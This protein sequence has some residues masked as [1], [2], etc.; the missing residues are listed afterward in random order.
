MAFEIFTSTSGIRVSSGIASLNA[1]GQLVFTTADLRAVSIRDRYVLLTDSASKRIAIR[2]PREGDLD[3]E[4]RNMKW[5]KTRTSGKV[6][7]RGAL[8]QLNFKVEQVVGRYAIMRKDDMLI[9]SP[10]VQ[11]TATARKK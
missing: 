8:L 5:N 2:A 7:V 9:I 10:E 6:Y 4:A 3:S 1:N 11:S